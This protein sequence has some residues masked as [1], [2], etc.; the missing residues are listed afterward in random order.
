MILLDTSNDVRGEWTSDAKNYR[1]LNFIRR[2][3]ESGVR[4]H[5]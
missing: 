1:R 3:K 2:T 5:S 4:Q